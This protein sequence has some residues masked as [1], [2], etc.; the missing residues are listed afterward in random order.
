M[1]QLT[2][3][4]TEGSELN[5]LK[6]IKTLPPGSSRFAVKERYDF[7][8]NAFDFIPLNGQGQRPLI[9]INGGEV[10]I[11]GPA[12]HLTQLLIPLLTF[13]VHE[14]SY[15]TADDSLRAIASPWRL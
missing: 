10:W 7:H 15:P 3:L 6:I 2:V 14:R 8:S 12:E 5:L 9:A 1:T 13:Q 11:R 4:K